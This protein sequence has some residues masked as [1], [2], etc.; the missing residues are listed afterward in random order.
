MGTSRLGRRR[1]LLSRAATNVRRH[2][3]RFRSAL[4]AALWAL[5]GRPDVAVNALLAA[6]PTPDPR[7]LRSAAFA[8][9]EAADAD[10]HLVFQRDGVDWMTDLGD[11]IGRE[12]FS[13]GEY[14][15]SEV[16]ALV[17][18]ARVHRSA[19]R[20]PIVVDIGA[21]IGTT[22]VPLARAGYRVLAIEPVPATYRMLM[23]NID[24]NDLGA[25]ITPVQAAISSREGRVQMSVTTGSGQSEVVVE[26][27]APAYTTYG[28]VPRSVVDV[29]AYGLDS[30][31]AAA[32]CPAADLAFVWCDAQGSEADVIATG[33]GTWALGVP[34]WLEVEPVAIDRH[35]G[36]DAFISAASTHFHRFV[37][38]ADLA[39]TGPTAAS[40]PIDELRTFVTDIGMGGFSDAL[41]VPP[42]NLNLPD[43]DLIDLT[44]LDRSEP[45]DE[46][47]AGGAS[48][49]AGQP[50]TPESVIT[51]RPTS[52]GRRG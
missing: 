30:F 1:E 6:A 32:S 11:E 5:A 43:H 19:S 40:R 39:D 7:H 20:H 34:L 38:S 51:R 46:N 13:E 42:H 15:G 31:L 52:P 21:N 2:P 36:I 28:F 14:E 49:R 10:A 45:T 4:Q 18:W 44:A 27:R 33:S 12:L 9:L 26:D 22:S 17:A 47:V 3:A 25:L 48:R 8:M 29:P 41:L 24:A 23:R 16:R 37:S 50:A 35:G